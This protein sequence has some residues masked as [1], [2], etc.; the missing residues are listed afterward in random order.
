MR[1]PLQ[2]LLLQPVYSSYH[3]ELAEISSYP[4][5]YKENAS[6][7]CHTNPSIMIAETWIGNADRAFDYTCIRP[8]HDG[9]RIDPCLPRLPHDVRGFE[10]AASLRRAAVED[11]LADLCGQDVAGSDGGQRQEHRGHRTERW[12]RRAVWNDGPP[13][14]GSHPV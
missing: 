8:E 12:R 13:E 14:G 10:R 7:F 3:S 2:P 9:L 4:P 1:Q 11:G 6:V 5:G